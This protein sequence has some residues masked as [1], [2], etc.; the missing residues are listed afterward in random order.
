MSNLARMDEN[1][2]LE[3]EYEQHRAII[4]GGLKGSSEALGRYMAS[5]GLES[6]FRHIGKLLG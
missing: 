6:M 1:R 4:K 3:Y 2:T 5:V